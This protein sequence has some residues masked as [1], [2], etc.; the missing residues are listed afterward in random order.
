MIQRLV[1][2]ITDF[3][4]RKNV[5]KESEHEIYTYGFDLIISGL[6]NVLLVIC[7]GIVIDKV[8]EALLYVCIMIIVRMYTGGYHADTHVMCNIIF[9]LAFLFSILV[10]KL[11]NSFEASWC[12][13]I[14]QCIGLIIVTRYAP[15]E[16]GNKEL[17][18]VQKEKYR[19]IAV[20]LYLIFTFVAVV[21]SIAE[22]KTLCFKNI[23]LCDCGLYINI[24]LIVIA[25]LLVIGIKKEERYYGEESF[26]DNC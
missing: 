14:L 6:M 16:N 15:L 22:H 26:K 24:V 2:N 10:M 21:L 18:M 5:V 25:C 17:N 11:V 20:T 3:F 8:W 9:L 4:V 12:I 7:A 13:W 1:S 19:N 23:S